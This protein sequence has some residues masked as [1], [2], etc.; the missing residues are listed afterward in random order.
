MTLRQASFRVV[1]S[2][3]VAAAL[4]WLTT[5]YRPIHHPPGVLAPEEPRQV[6]LVTPPAPFAREGWTLRPLALYDIEARVLGRERYSG[7]AAARLAPYDLALGWGRMSDEA[8]L[9]RLEISQAHRRY[10]WQYWGKP[11][12]PEKEIV[13]HSANVHVIPSN[14]AV[15]R[16]LG[17][18]RTGALVKIHGYLV[19]AVHPSASTPWRSSLKRDDQGDGACEIIYVTSLSHRDGRR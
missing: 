3:L 16:S 7:N 14:D 10:R 11:P 15:L 18:L 5:P 17:R 2:G 12:V 19:E 9:E 6:E 4:L 1:A 13:T 8:V